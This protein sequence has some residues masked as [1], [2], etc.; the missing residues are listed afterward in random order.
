MAD[1]RNEWQTLIER[2][3]DGQPIC[4][5]GDAYYW[6]VGKSIDAEGNCRTD[7]LSCRYGC[8]ANQLDARDYIAHRVV[9]DLNKK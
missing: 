7:M 5:C 3:A 6:P 2:Y 8:S 1:N 4:N 9:R